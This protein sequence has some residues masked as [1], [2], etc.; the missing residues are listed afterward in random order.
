MEGITV[1]QTISKILVIATGVCFAYQFAYLFIPLF[2]KKKVPKA[3][4]LHR[5]AILIPARNE[6][7]VIAHLI[8]SIHNQE[9]PSD[10]I[11]IF[12]VAD[13]CTDNTARIAQEH[14]ATVF[15]RYNTEQIGKGY[16]LNYLLGKIDEA[17]GLD[18]YDAFMIFD[19][20]NLL[21]SDYL[22][23]INNV[24]SNGYEVFCGYRNSKNF[25]SNWVSAGYGV[26]YLHDSTHLNLSRMS[27]GTSCMVNGTGFGFSREVLKKCNQWEFFTLT[28]DIEFSIWCAANGIKIGYCHDAILFDEQPLTFRQSWRQRTRWTQGGIQ[29]LFKRS[30]ELLGGIFKGGWRSYSCFEFTTL[31]AWG[32]G[33]GM[34]SGLFASVSTM[35]SLGLEA[36]LLSVP[37]ALVGS[38]FSLLLIGAWTVI[39]ERKRIRAATRHKIL[40]IFAFPIYMLTFVPIAITAP[41]CKFQWKPVEHTV[42]LSESEMK[43]H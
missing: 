27:I 39:T 4:I 43:L 19:A 41:F 1:L 22:S 9:Y 36:F 30:K 10:L 31:S 25:G 18:S 8:D 34:L 2:A 21:Q 40:G 35:A 20:D 11:S 32:C 38:Y 15:S 13:N 29:I 14:G 28:E 24:Y 23:Q 42:A 16:A 12:V 17:E 5:Y 26:W 33:L 37:A 3:S 7:K 6:E